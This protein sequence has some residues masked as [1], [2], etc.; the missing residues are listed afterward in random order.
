[1][2]FIRRAGAC[3]HFAINDIRVGRPPL[4]R[5][6]PRLGP[7]FGE[8]P[9]DGPLP[10]IFT[11]C[12]SGYFSQHA[13]PLITSM[14]RNAPQS[15]LHF[16]LFHPSSDVRESLSELRQAFPAVSLTWTSEQPDF[17]GLT[18][19]QSRR[20]YINARFV[21]LYQAL[22]RTRRPIVQIDVDCL[23]RKPIDQIMAAADGAD[24]G[25]FLRP[26]YRDPGKKVLGA[27]VYAAPT[28]RGLRF[29][30]RL[31]QRIAGHLANKAQTEKLDQRLL[32]MTFAEQNRDLALW[33]IDHRFIDPAHGP[34]SIIWMLKGS[35]KRG[36]PDSYANE[37]A[38]LAGSF[39]SRR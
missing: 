38:R 28:E 7:V 27:M 4:E 24:V 16:H 34:D 25:L 5:S 32:W 39:A 9:A 1:M 37:R 26:R 13:R 22:L 14:A 36:I 3:L 10:Q 35:P 2:S 30:E 20:F 23:V 29:F 17:E 8:W 18:A 19:L 6:L 33:R 11:A 12:D 15:A 31:S 21:R